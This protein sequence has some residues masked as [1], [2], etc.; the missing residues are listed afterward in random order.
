MRFRTWETWI[1]SINTTYD[2]DKF[3]PK[4]SSICQISKLE[5][6]IDD[7]DGNVKHP[8]FYD[9]L[10][11]GLFTLN[12]FGMV[13]VDNFQRGFKDF[14]QGKLGLGFRHEHGWF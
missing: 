12:K 11:L 1:P 9:S 13:L 14:K 4:T 7:E 2:V 3:D 5:F 6:K 8:S 10:K